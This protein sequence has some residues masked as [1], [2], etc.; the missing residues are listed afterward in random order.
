MKTHIVFYYYSH[1]V[2]SMKYWLLNIKLINFIKCFLNSNSSFS[3]V[4]FITLPNT[5][6]L[7]PISR[8][9]PKIP[10]FFSDLLL[11]TGSTHLILCISGFLV[12]KS[13][14]HC[15]L[16]LQKCLRNHGSWSWSDFKTTEYIDDNSFLHSS[17]V[18]AKIYFKIVEAGT[19]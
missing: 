11:S 19:E 14:G 3:H 1:M 17:I 4:I 9:F 13:L 5:G 16:S 7:K 2:L 10:D 15:S 8:Y 6:S 18:W 12:I